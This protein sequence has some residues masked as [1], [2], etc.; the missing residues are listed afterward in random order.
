MLNVEAFLS[1]TTFIKVLLQHVSKYIKIFCSENLDKCCDSF[2]LYPQN[3]WLVV[4]LEIGPW[5]LVTATS[6]DDDSEAYD[7]DLH[8]GQLAKAG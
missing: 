3:G 2:R 1:F 8:D 6:N 4:A 7:T 5:Y